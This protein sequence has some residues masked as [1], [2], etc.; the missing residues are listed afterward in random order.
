MDTSF[1]V[2]WVEMFR[3]GGV[4]ADVRLEAARGLLAPRPSEQLALLVLL[5]GDDDPTISAAAETTLGQVPSARLQALIARPD[6]PSEIKTFF[7]SRGIV[8]APSDIEDETPLIDVGPEPPR[9]LDDDP[10]RPASGEPRVA[11]GAPGALQK[12]AQMT[13]PQR[14]SLAMKGTREERAILIRDAN[15]IVSLAVLAS[16]K[17]TETEVE[18]IARMTSVMEDVLRTI[19]STRAWMKSYAICSA[20]VKN[21]KTPPAISLNLMPRLTDRDL[22]NLST[23]RNV[24]EVVRMTARRRTARLK[25]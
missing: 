2:P 8:A 1:R 5:T 18:S 6:T 9:I 11:E 7:E 16:P 17:L 10:L 12:I 23:D 14:L 20:L 15:K 24:P 3:R 4:D 22:R 25:T 21:P 19:A 13:I